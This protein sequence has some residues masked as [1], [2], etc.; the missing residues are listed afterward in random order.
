MASN[1]ME[2][3]S[4]GTANAEFKPYAYY[5]YEEDA[6]TVYIK[7]DADYA[8]RLNSR[9]TVYRSLE[10]NDVVG[11]QIKSIRHV[12]DEIGYFDVA[13]RGNDGRVKLALLFVSFRP[14][15]Q[16]AP[17]IYRRIGRELTRHQLEIDFS[18]LYCNA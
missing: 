7:G 12:L 13:I 9:V 2:L 14:A 8:C 17:E 10:D 15:F 11:C 3:I 5:G 4:T 1:L 16:E 6:L 18:S